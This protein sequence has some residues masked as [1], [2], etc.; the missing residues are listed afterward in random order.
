MNPNRFRELVNWVEAV[1]KIPTR[2]RIFET[3][4]SARCVNDYDVTQPK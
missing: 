2:M 1:K 4:G 3:T